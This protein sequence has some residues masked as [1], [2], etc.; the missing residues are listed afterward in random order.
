MTLLYEQVRKFDLRIL[1]EL[2]R[3]KDQHVILTYLRITLRHYLLF[4]TYQCSKDG[5]RR[6]DH[7][8][9]ALSHPLVV[10]VH[11]AGQESDRALLFLEHD[12]VELRVAFN[13]TCGNDTCRNSYHA[14]SKEGDHYRHYPAAQRYRVDI[15][16]AYGKQRGCRP[17][18]AREGILE[19]FGL[20]LVLKGVHAEGCGDHEY[21]YHHHRRKKLLFLLIQDIDYNTEGIVTLIYL[22]KTENTDYAEDPESN[23]ARRKYE[24]QIIREER[25]QVNDTR[26]GHHEP[27]SRAEHGLLGIQKIRGHH[28]K[29]IF[30]RKYDYR[31]ELNRIENSRITRKF[32]VRLH[33]CDRKAY[34]YH[35]RD[36]EIKQRT[37]KIR[38]IAYLDNVK[39]SFSDPVTS[40]FHDKPQ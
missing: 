39:Y 22:E 32:I 5:F 16:I 34:K 28:A 26:D 3:A 35:E 30:N 33:Q 13:E 19:D 37:R 24:R 7:F 12:P 9:H 6:E 15:A 31:H 18:D 8:L 21:Q 36:K 4:V 1:I 27:Q 11:R 10:F 25:E 20:R 2:P 40:L 17:P 29:N 14:H 23:R 38:Y